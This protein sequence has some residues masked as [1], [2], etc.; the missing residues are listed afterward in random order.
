[1]LRVDIGIR[2][3]CCIGTRFNITDSTT[4]FVKIKGQ[5]CSLC[6]NKRAIIGKMMHNIIY[7]ES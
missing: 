6:C 3:Q 2:Y 7:N 5:P 1:M 4:V